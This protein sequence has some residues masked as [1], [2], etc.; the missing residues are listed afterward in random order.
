MRKLILNNLRKRKICENGLFS[1]LCYILED[2][3]TIPHGSTISFIGHGSDLL[4][5]LLVF[6]LVCASILYNPELIFRMRAHFGDLIKVTSI[7]FGFC[8]TSLTFFIQSASTWRRHPG[9][10]ELGKLAVELHVWSLITWLSI[11]A[12]ILVL[13]FWGGLLNPKG[14]ASCI[15]YSAL[16][17]LFAYGCFQI[18]SQVLELSVLFHR[19]DVFFDEP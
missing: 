14:V 17:A 12:Y 10:D 6:A 11:L 18:L 15:I 8:L 16:A 13:W 4:L 3:S 19:R 7:L 1:Y 9:V 2:K 5:T